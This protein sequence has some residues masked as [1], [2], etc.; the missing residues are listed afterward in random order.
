V[1]MEPLVWDEEIR[2]A[3]C[4]RR[5]SGAK[6]SLILSGSSAHAPRWWPTLSDLGA[7]IW[8]RLGL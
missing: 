4:G 1:H 3:F 8:R 2:V 7:T 5:L 6:C